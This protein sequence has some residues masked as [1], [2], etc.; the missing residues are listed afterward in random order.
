MLQPAADTIAGQLV[1]HVINNGTLQI[2]VQTPG[3][4]N[5]TGGNYT[6]LTGRGWTIS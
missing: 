3:N 5:I 6:T 2:Q 1:A 4:L